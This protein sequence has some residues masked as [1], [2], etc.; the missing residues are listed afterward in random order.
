MVYL[1]LVI[2]INEEIFKKKNSI[3][4]VYLGNPFSCYINDLSRITVSDSLTSAHV[5]FPLSFDIHHWDLDDYHKPS[6]PLDVMI[7]GRIIYFKIG[8]Y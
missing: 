6:I 4:F 8:I 2:K 7:T 5:G 3:S 1:Y